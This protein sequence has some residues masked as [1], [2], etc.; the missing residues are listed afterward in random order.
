MTLGHF[1]RN[2]PRNLFGRRAQSDIVTLAYPEEKRP[3]PPRNRGLHRLMKRADGQVRCVACM[4][5]PTACPAHCISIVPEESEDARIEKRP[6]IFRSTSFVAWCAACV[7]RPAP[8]TPS[9]WTPGCTPGQ[10]SVAPMRSWTRK[11]FSRAAKFPAQLKEAPDFFGERASRENSF[12]TV[13]E[14]K[15]ML[16]VNPLCGSTAGR[17]FF[18]YKL[19]SGSCL[20][21]LECAR[22]LESGSPMRLI[23][24][25]PPYDSR[26]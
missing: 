14:Q 6:H 3:Y 7:S 17:D 8:A 9:A 21:P 12:L 22:P 5:C 10:P 24:W 15:H 19:N 1:L 18:P 2:W 23:L 16:L 11:N 4:M 26:G 13:A 20:W 25:L